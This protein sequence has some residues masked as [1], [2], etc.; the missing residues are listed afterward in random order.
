[1][2]SPSFLTLV[3]R[4][5]R[6]NPSQNSL[7]VIIASAAMLA[8]RFMPTYVGALQNSDVLKIEYTDLLGMEH[9]GMMTTWRERAQSTCS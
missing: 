2:T 1:M 5:P 3:T 6:I 7:Y 4:Q 8:L 9:Y